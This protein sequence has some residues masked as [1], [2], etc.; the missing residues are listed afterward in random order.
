M[1]RLVGLL[2]LV[3]LVG[4]GIRGW[5]GLLG[6]M[7][8]GEFVQAG[9]QNLGA[10]LDEWV[11]RLRL[12]PRSRGK[13]IVRGGDTRTAKPRMVNIDAATMAYA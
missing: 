1:V 9:K 10:Y 8:K 7:D 5:T 4:Y 13:A 11:A 6:K 12:E 3:R 2:G